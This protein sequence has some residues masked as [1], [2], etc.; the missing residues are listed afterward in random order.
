MHEHELTKNAIA[1]GQILIVATSHDKLGDTD[2]A[3]GCWVRGDELAH[4]D[5]I[6]ALHAQRLSP[7]GS[8]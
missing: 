6:T 1:K 7:I 3:T 2:A 5:S 8:A 4:D